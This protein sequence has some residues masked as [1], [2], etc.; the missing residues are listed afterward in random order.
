MQC[1]VALR[2]DFHV[3]A[4][5]QHYPFYSLSPP[6]IMKILCPIALSNYFV[7]KNE[8]FTHCNLGTQKNSQ[9]SDIK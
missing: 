5:S 4:A 1:A 9:K 8:R 2:I 3:I 7:Q 6:A